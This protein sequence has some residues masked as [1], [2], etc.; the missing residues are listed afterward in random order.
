MGKLTHHLPPALRQV[1]EALPTS[2][3]VGGCVRDLWLG[4]EPK[5]YDVEV[6]GHT[7]EELLAKLAPFG[8]VDLVGRSFGVIKLT[9]GGDTYDVAVPRRETLVGPGHK[10]FAV[11]TN[12][13]LSLAQAASRRDFTFNALFLEPRTG[14]ILDF[15]NGQEDLR[16]GVIRH[17][18]PAFGEDPLRVLRAM[19]FAG[20]FG[21]RVAPETVAV[22]RSMQSRFFELTPGRF[23][24]EWFKW[25]AKSVQPSLGLLFLRDSG[26]LSHFPEVFDLIGLEQDPGFH[27]EGDAFTHTCLCCD[28][29]A[30]DPLWAGSSPE[31]RALLMFGTL[32]HDVG[33]VVATAAVDG[34]IAS[35]GHAEAGV[36]LVHQFLARIQA[37][38]TF[39]EKVAPLVAN[40]MVRLQPPSARSV[41]RLAVR[42]QPATVDDLVAVM[43]ADA[44]GHGGAADHGDCLRQIEALAARLQINDAPPQRILLGRH[45]IDKGF[46]PGVAM[47]RLLDQAFEAQLNGAFSD[48]TGAE[49]WLKATTHAP[50]G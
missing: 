40:H 19:Q 22:C 35:P 43:R 18:S 41:R 3:L 47:G 15:F 14:E 17:T 31:R 29:L 12:G 39:H 4:V 28:A 42:L 8:R 16:S 32:L 38:N 5:D 33:K 1:L 36:A 25:A 20:R 34:K 6:F 23:W 46:A 27:P 9:V 2:Y 13:D 37:P 48:L 49:R 30:R 24:E 7:Y 21:F 11:E 45:L 44:N 26:W 50:E 10:G